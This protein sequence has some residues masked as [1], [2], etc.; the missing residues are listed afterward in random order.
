[1]AGLIAFNQAHADRELALFQQELFDQA[2]AT[3]GLQD[4]AYLEARA[5][6]LRLAGREGIDRM[7]AD[8]RA[9]ALVAPTNGPAWT[10]DPVNGDHFMGAASTLPAVAGYP[11][12]SVP[13]GEVGGLPVGLSFIGPAW[14][15]ARMLAYGH[16]FEL[17]AGRA[18]APTYAA[19]LSAALADRG[20]LSPLSR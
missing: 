5:T 11:H 3:K 7:L 6:S 12:L 14:S 10:V 20:L 4:P 19:T 16:A 13:M 17:R 1:M 18:A 15:D 8:N 2:E 9:D